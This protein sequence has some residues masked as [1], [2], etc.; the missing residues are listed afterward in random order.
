VW[1]LDAKKLGSGSIARGSRDASVA[2]RQ[3]ELIEVREEAGHEERARIEQ[4][5]RPA[6]RSGRY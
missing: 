4:T 6:H 3:H 5:V 1:V 2:G